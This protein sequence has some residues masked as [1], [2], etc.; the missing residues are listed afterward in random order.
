M[1]GHRTIKQFLCS[2]TPFSK[3]NSPRRRLWFTTSFSGVCGTASLAHSAT[4]DL[5]HLLKQGTCTHVSKQHAQV[6]TMPCGRPLG[7]SCSLNSAA[8]DLLPGPHF[9][10]QFS[11]T[12]ELPGTALVGFQSICG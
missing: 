10:M 8:T 2:G 1:G 9:S 5:Q 7:A 12:Q 4:A 3:K 6:P 11:N